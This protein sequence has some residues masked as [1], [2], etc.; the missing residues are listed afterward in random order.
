[1]S[2]ENVARF[3]RAVE[4]LNRGDIEAVLEDH[5]MS[6]G[7]RSWRNGW[8]VSGSSSGPT[9]PTATAT[10]PGSDPGAEFSPDLLGT[11]TVVP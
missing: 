10:A 5:P 4:A 8:A 11:M 7:M 9:S 6:S 2:Q 1:M 3:E